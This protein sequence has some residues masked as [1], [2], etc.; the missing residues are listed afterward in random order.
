MKN[1]LLCLLAL[2]GSLQA[3]ELVSSQIPASAKW[4]LHLDMDAMRGSMTGI[5][6]LAKIQADHG[7]KLQA[8]KRISSVH[9]VN[10]LQGITLFGD[11][12]PEHAVALVHGKF[13]QAHM[14][15]VVKA[16]DDYSEET[17]AGFTIHSWKDK[18]ASQNAAFAN[19]NLLVFSRQEDALKQE[20]DTLKANTPATAD[21]VFTANGGKPIIAATANLAK[22]ELPADAS[23]ILRLASVLRLAAGESNG[24]FSIHMGAES[25]DPKHANRLRRMLDGILA[26]AEAGNP[27]LGEADFQSEVVATQDKPGVNVALSLPVPTWLGI[28]NDAAEKKKKDAR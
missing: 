21:P 4:V 8:F 14:V 7:A 22:I 26:L 25:A 1:H 19:D 18:K 27:K 5:A 2:T 23:K 28:L 13:D 15:D 3:A 9:L 24:R 12:K 16:S 20:L 11:G 17:H 6:V 10:D